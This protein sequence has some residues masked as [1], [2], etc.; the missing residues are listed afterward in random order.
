MNNF[1]KLTIMFATIILCINA[2]TA[3]SNPNGTPESTK[4]PHT[5]TPS[6]EWFADEKQHWHKCTEDEEKLD[7]Q[8]HTM[9]NG[10]CNVCKAKTFRHEDHYD[11]SFFNSF[12]H[13]VRTIHSYTDGKISVD[14][15]EYV[16]AGNSGNIDSLKT[17]TDGVLASEAEYKPTADNKSTYEAVVTFFNEDK[18]KHICEYDETGDM[19]RETLYNTKGEVTS[20]ITIT[21]EYDEDG[22][23]TFEKYYS[24]SKLVKEIEY[25]VISSDSWGGV[26]FNLRVTTYNADGTTTVK[27]YDESGNEVK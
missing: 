23:K 15:V 24:N 12:G 20:D 10:L 7:A 26:I 6:E 5:H 2:L 22:R 3:C 18:T 8:D 19:I 4:E 25:V 27:T 9:S 11:A 1:K 21:H 16:Y 14:T 17:Y 13:R